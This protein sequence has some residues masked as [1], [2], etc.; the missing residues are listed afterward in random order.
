MSTSIEEPPGAEVLS[1]PKYRSFT[2]AYKLRI[3]EEADACE[4]R[5]EIG[6]LLRREGLYSSHLSKWREVRLRGALR[7]LSE[8]RGRKPKHSPEELERLRPERENE[9]LREEL[10][11]P[12]LI[13][14][15]QKKLSQLLG[16]PQEPESGS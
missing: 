8:Q 2:A 14:D 3:L 16:V 4:E 10:R 13:I 6:A 5:G 15:V 11:P 1:R 9:R 12:T 7:G